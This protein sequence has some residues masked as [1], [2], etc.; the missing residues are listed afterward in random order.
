M[1]DLSSQPDDD[2]AAAHDLADG[3]RRGLEAGSGM[4]RLTKKLEQVDTLS[5]QN[6]LL[7][8]ALAHLMNKHGLTTLRIGSFELENGPRVKAWPDA[9]TAGTADKNYNFEIR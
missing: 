9:V 5:R 1:S 7:S 3:M 6:D 2:I 4:Q 8:G